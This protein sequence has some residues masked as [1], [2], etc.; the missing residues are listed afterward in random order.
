MAHNFKVL[1][2]HIR[3]F[4]GNIDNRFNHQRGILI[5]GGIFALAGLT[6]ISQSS[7]ATFTAATEA[8]SGAVSGSAATVSGAAN[9]PGAS[10]GAAVRFG[11]TTSTA[12]PVVT[13]TVVV[14]GKSNIWEMAF[15]PT[16]EALFNERKG[17]MSVLKNGTVSTV[18]TISD[19]KALGEGGLMGLAVDAQFSENR[20]VY[21]CIDTTAGDIRV[22]RWKLATDLSGLS[23]RQDIVTGI[24]MN[25]SGRHSGCRLA[26]GPDGYLW[27]GTGDAATGGTPQNPTSLNGKILRVDRNGVAAPGNVGSGFDARIYSYGH[28]NVQ[29]IA[30]FAAP[31]NNVLGVNVEHGPNIDDEVNL[32]QLGNY[33]WAPPNGAYNENVPMT[34][35]VKFPA[36]IPAIWSSGNPTQAPSGAT[37]LNGPQWKGWDGAIVV[38]VLKATHLKVLRLDA[39]NKVSKE[40]KI[41]SG[42]Y[43]RLRSAVQGPDGNLYITTD[44]ATDDKIIKLTPQ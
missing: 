14:S 33:G 18:A 37:T 44:N 4:A 38:A 26:Y 30:F 2:R 35:K 39:A 21:T 7:A 27:I 11:I 6:L 19:V 13:P 24:T 36:A 1:Q 23:D 22:L 9:A 42:T 17:T 43:G 28:R 29:G 10:G 12:T 8:E 3:R 5:M 16:G 25:P 40:E 15:L 20:Y 34:D 41:L 32:L 31:R